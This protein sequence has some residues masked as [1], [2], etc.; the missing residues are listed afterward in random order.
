VSA[1]TVPWKVAL[2]ETAILAVADADTGFVAAT[3]EMSS[4]YLGGRL[5]DSGG[6]TGDLLQVVLLCCVVKDFGDRDRGEEAAE[7]DS[8]LAVLDNDSVLL[9]ADWSWSL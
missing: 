6:T 4:G 3:E 8:L 2:G 5:K 1:S 7:E 9:L